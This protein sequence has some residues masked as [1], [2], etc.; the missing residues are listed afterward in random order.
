MK[1]IGRA[2]FNEDGSVS[3]VITRKGKRRAVKFTSVSSAVTYC[4]ENRI[5]ANM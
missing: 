2:I 5:T 1:R 4:N 3:I